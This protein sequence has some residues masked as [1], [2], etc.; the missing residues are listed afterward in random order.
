MSFLQRWVGGVM[1]DDGVCDG[2][3]LG[4]GFPGQCSLLNLLGQFISNG[5]KLT[6][7]LRREE[8][9]NKSIKIY[10][11]QFLPTLA[12]SEWKT[13]SAAK[14][15]CMFVTKKRILESCRAG[16]SSCSSEF[17]T[18]YVLL[19]FSI[20]SLTLMNLASFLLGLFCICWTACL[21]L[22]KSIN[23]RPLLSIFF[24][25]NHGD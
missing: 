3:G 1:A 17:S 19:A 25:N 23:F 13:S 14:R 18:S 6:E 5:F 10:V 11:V 9:M 12:V 16:S 21:S 22:S 8:I 4:E 2:S 7:D 15:V 20:C 24:C